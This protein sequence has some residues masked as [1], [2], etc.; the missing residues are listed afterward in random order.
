[1]DVI[2]L[3]RTAVKLG[4]SDLHLT[5]GAPPA[6]RIH[7]ALKL[8]KAPPLSPED[9][10]DLVGQLVTSDQMLDFSRDHQLNFS[11]HIDALGRFR[12]SI[13][14]QMGTLEASIRASSTTNHSLDEL[15]VPEGLWRLATEPRGLILVTGP[16]GHGKTTTFHALIDHVNESL[17][18]KVVTLE[19]P[20]EHIHPHKQGLVVQ[21]EV[22]SDTLDYATGLE[23]ALRQ[24][25]D[26]IAVA[27]LGDLHTIAH[28]LAAAESG[29]LVIGT[30]PTGNAE[31]SLSRMVE[32]FQP[33]QQDLIRGQL[34]NNLLAICSQRLLPRADGLGRVLA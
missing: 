12:V 26:V 3:L 34:A 16:S 10:E 6:V 15:G 21:L 32:V 1:M 29:H 22:G 2:K 24:D 27:E 14:S 9:C 31:D 4:A 8:L 11:K 7:G 33:A 30:L 23:Q 18:R 13:Y 19:E 20:I 5:A 17:R 25:A 28:A